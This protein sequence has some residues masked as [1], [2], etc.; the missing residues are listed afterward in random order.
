MKGEGMGGSMCGREKEDWDKK[1]IRDFC[2]QRTV[3]GLSKSIGIGSLNPTV[4]INHRHM[5]TCSNG[6][7]ISHRQRPIYANAI[8][9]PSVISFIADN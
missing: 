6:T 4:I 1:E 3:V 2:F 5:S 9:F 7:K 8:I